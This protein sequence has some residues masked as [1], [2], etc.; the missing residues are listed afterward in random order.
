MATIRRARI[1]DLPAMQQANLTC[2]PE[3][4]QMK[5]YL[6]HGLSWPQLSY[7]AEDHKGRIVGYVLAKME[8]EDEGVPHGHITSLAVF[9]SYRKQGLATK[10]MLQA[11]RAMVEAFDSQYLSLHVR[12]TNRAAFTLYH[13]TLGFDIDDIE[14]K[15]YADGENAYSMKK[16]LTMNV[17]PGTYATISGSRQLPLFSNNI[18]GSYNALWCF[19]HKQVSPD[20]IPDRTMFFTDSASK[21]EEVKAFLEKSSEVTVFHTSGSN[22][23]DVLANS[24]KSLITVKHI[25]GQ[26][27]IFFDSD[28][29]PEVKVGGTRGKAKPD[30]FMGA[31]TLQRSLD[32]IAGGV[33]GS[34]CIFE[35]SKKCWRAEYDLRTHKGR[36][37]EVIIQKGGVLPTG[38]PEREPI[39]SGKKDSKN[40]QDL[41]AE[42][43]KAN[44]GDVIK[45]WAFPLKPKI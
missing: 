41:K 10:L 11:E 21:E 25:D 2:L 33:V 42:Y 14:E 35:N 26:D 12:E 28:G 38:E 30:T 24:D 3:N 18:D 9:R 5:Y 4:Y 36:G 19:L 15:Y 37:R 16:E 45:K 8:E 32:H 27:A 7:I 34:V 6:Y 31:V 23:W 29:K 44:C 17:A 1:E 43:A 20:K 40:L 39:D 13:E 22:K